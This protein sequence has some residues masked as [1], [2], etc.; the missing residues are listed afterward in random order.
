MEEI[1]VVRLTKEYEN[2]PA[3][4]E[5]TIVHKYNDSVF[6]VE[7]VDSDGDYIDPV[8]IPAD[9]LELIWQYSTQQWMK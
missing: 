1:D 9:V 2:I 4:T 7:F 5:G 8:T 6:E 3:G